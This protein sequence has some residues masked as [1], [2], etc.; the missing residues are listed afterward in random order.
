[1][2]IYGEWLIHYTESIVDRY[3]P[4]L[5]S[6][7]EEVSRWEKLKDKK[8]IFELRSEAPASDPTAKIEFAVLLKEDVE[9]KS[10]EMLEAE[11]LV[12]LF[13]DRS[14]KL[15]DYSRIEWPTAKLHAQHCVTEILKEC[16]DPV[17]VH[18]YELIK[19]ILVNL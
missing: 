11:R 12:E 9:D 1:M 14:N 7:S 18:K 3:Y 6:S 2:N 5:P 4:I 13:M 10:P 16:T 17:I 15:S 8:V 19:E